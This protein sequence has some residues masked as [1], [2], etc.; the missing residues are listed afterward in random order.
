[1]ANKYGPIFTMKMGVNRALVVSNSEITKECFTTN[2]KALASRPRRMAMEILGYNFLATPSSPYG[3]YWRETR[4]IATVELLSNHRLEKLKHVRESEVTASIKGLFKDCQ[5]SAT[6]KVS[7]EMKHWLEGTTFDIII[8]IIEGKR[9]TSQEGTDL[10]E[11]AASFFTLFGKFVVSDALPFLRWLD[12][13]GNEKLMKK[14]AKEFD[15]ILQQWLDEHKIK[16]GSSEVEGDEDFIYVMLSLLYDN[17][18]QLPDSD[19]DTVIKAL[20]L[21]TRGSTPNKLISI[22]QAILKETMRLYPAAPLLLPHQSME[23]C[24]IS[25]YHVPAGTQLFVNA[26]KVHHDPKVWKEPCKFLP[27]RFLTTHKDIDLRGQNFELIPFGSGRRI[28]P[29]ISFAFQVMP[30]ILASLLHG[31]DLATPLDEPVDMEEAK[32]LTITRA[33]PLKVLLTPRLS[34]SLYD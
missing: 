31:F 17:A 25:G 14:T 15:I 10:H 27:E 7:V 19:A 8:R 5:N 30:L 21:A 32:S 34:A 18:K 11:H 6:G 9:Y 12:I 13:G 1:M 33:T 29:G 2:D 24:T 3:S 22:Y 28:C 26:W 20:C 16:R 23:D 4:K